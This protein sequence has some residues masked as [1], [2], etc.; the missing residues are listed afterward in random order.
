MAFLD[1][2]FKI[3]GALEFSQ[4]M[5]FKIFKLHENVD[6]SPK[7]DADHEIHHES[8]SIFRLHTLKSIL[9]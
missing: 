4:K 9:L 1:L 2:N 3:F 8:T 7:F 6:Y 5:V